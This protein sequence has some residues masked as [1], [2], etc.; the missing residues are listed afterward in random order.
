[1]LICNNIIMIWYDGFMSNYV[2]IMCNYI[3]ICY[4]GGVPLC[5]VSYVCYAYYVY[6]V[7]YV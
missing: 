3:L 2:I 1:M 7:Y 4:L 6:Y 5:Y